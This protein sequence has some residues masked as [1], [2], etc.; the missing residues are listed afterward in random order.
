VSWGV[1]PGPR[2]PPPPPPSPPRSLGG[3]PP[4]PTAVPFSPPRS[5]P[6]RAVEGMPARPRTVS[7][8]LISLG[9][10]AL[11]RVACSDGGRH[12]SSHRS[13]GFWERGAQNRGKERHLVDAS[14]QPGDKLFQAIV[15]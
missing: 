12:G 6:N 10:A 8:R 9:Q 4:P 11:R 2:R 7:G 13:L 5:F 15:Q 1:P 14:R 3:V